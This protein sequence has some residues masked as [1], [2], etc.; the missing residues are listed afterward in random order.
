MKKITW[1]WKSCANVPL[2]CVCINSQ[3]F[4]TRPVRLAILDL[5]AFNLQIH[6]G[7]LLTNPN[8]KKEHVKWLKASFIPL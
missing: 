6:H 1:V 8:V 4:V 2:K 3:L 7:H 5:E